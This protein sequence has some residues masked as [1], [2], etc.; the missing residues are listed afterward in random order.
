MNILPSLKEKKRYVVFE[1]VSDKKYS[2]NDVNKEIELRMKDYLG[3][4]GLS[5]AKPELIKNKFKGNKFIIK[6]AHKY[7]QELIT[8]IILGKSIKNEPV[9]IKS[10]I[11]SGTLKKAE[12]CLWGGYKWINKL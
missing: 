9:I 1:I 4:W 8:G 10:I 6:V 3:I 12:S 7:V 11:T 5:L 2:V